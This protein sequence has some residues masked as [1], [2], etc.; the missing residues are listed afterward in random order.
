M[1]VKEETVTYSEIPSFHMPGGTEENHENAHQNIWSS[2]QDL[3]P[4]PPE[5]KAVLP[6][7]TDVQSPLKDIK[8]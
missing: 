3:N 7:L 4:E 1:D 8:L 2:G 5:Y 6:T